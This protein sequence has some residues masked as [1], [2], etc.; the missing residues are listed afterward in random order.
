MKIIAYLLAQSSKDYYICIVQ[1]SL[2]RKDLKGWEESFNYLKFLLRNEKELL[3]KG[4]FSETD[5][6]F[7]IIN[8][9]K[10][11]STLLSDVDDLIKK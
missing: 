9:I 6:F 5:F 7:E 2:D 11:L 8:T 10:E 3:A 4:W 1:M